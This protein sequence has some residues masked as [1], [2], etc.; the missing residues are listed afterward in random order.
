MFFSQKIGIPK[1]LM[2]H[3]KL[4]L[5]FF[6]QGGGREKLV[7]ERV[8]RVIIPQRGAGMSEGFSSQVVLH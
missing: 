4:R 8:E 7:V 3:R 5:I 2:H 1:H 6:W